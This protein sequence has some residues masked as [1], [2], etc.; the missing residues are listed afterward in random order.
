MTAWTLER[1][2]AYDDRFGHADQFVIGELLPS[3]SAASS[4]CANAPRG[5]NSRCI[6]RML[7]KHSSTVGFD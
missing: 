3:S 2:L 5:E 6:S 1:L 7:W 4:N